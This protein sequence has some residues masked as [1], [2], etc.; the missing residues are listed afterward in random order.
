MRGI[1]NLNDAFGYVPNRTGWKNFI[2]KVL[3][4][5]S[6]MRR[7]QAPLL[8]KMLEPRDSEFILDVGCGGG[9]FT[10]EIAKRCKLGIGIDWNL[11]K[12]LSLAMSKQPKVAYVKGDV[13]KLPFMSG[14]FEKLLLSSILQMVK[15]DRALLMECYRVLKENGIMVLSVPI[16]YIHLKKLNN[17]KPQLK[18][19]FG[20]LGKSYYD[21][22]EVIGLLVTE[23]FEIIQTEYSPKRWGSLIF[24]A[25]L[26]LWYRFGFTYYSPFLFPLL[27]PI[28]YFDRFAN[29]RQIGSELVIKARKVS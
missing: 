1:L 8:M 2:L 23:G 22:D 5:P 18:E 6:M 14:V 15:D 4:Y 25:T 11:N 28:A 17:Y 29:K 24:E 16:E 13:Q 21:Y 3:G 7:I 12:G 20:S 27:Y 26:F 10:Y 19:M 9:F